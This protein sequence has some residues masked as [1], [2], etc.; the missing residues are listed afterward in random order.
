MDY[1]I[2]F[3]KDAAQRVEAGVSARMTLT[4]KNNYTGTRIFDFTIDKK[5][6]ADTD[7]SISY[8]SVQ[9]YT[10]SAVTPEVTLMYNGELMVKIGTIRLHILTTL[11]HLQVRRSPSPEQEISKEK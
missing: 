6:V 8:D 5:N 2:T 10:G 4:G 9:S 7:V 3:D 11:Q 1:T